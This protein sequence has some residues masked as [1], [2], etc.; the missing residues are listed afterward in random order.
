MRLNVVKTFVGPR[1]E[2]A[3]FKAAGFR[4]LGLTQG[5]GRHAPN[6]VGRR[7]RKKVFAYEL[8]PT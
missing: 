3:C 4:Y 8:V 6:G 7:S 1:H 5:R 2:G